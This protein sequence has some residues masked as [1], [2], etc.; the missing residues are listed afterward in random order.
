LANAAVLLLLLCWLQ[1]EQAFLQ[2]QPLLARALDNPVIGAADWEG[3]DAPSTD[4]G[5]SGLA[6][7]A[8][9]GRK[10][11]MQNG[12]AIYLLAAD[13]AADS[14]EREVRG[15]TEPWVVIPF[16]PFCQRSTELPFDGDALLDVHLLTAD[17]AAARSL[18]A[19]GRVKQGEVVKATSRPCGVLVFC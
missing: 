18:E 11:S 16:D 2:E 1:V 12:S 9:V 8:S 10:I 17:A 3:F 15:G 19:R 14:I 13:E 5:M 6:S 7:G 4:A